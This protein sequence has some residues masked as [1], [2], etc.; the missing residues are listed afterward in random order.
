MGKGSI[1][2]GMA[3]EVEAVSMPPS[4]EYTAT[5]LS[6]AVQIE[7]PEVVAFFACFL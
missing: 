4:E 2:G 1:E 5:H 7:S 6:V 3:W